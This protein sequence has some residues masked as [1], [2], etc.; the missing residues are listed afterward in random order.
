MSFAEEI[1]QDA[2]V[3]A[4][5]QWPQDGVPRNPGAWLTATAKH[6][7]VDLVRQE[8]RLGQKIVELDRD[9]QVRQA[10]DVRNLGA[11]VDVATA[12]STTTSC[13]SCSSP[14]TRCSPPRRGSR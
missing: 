2:P 13:D 10:M 1:A 5:E 6:R 11:E 8:V 9:L 14:A 4:V 12:T 3:A 7:A